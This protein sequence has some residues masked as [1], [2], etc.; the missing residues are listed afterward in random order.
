VAQT[1]DI[2]LEDRARLPEQVP[3][4]LPLPAA[5]QPERK[6]GLLAGLQQAA[7][8]ALEHRRLFLLLPYAMIAGL[9]VA[10][11]LPADPQPLLLGTAWPCSRWRSAGARLPGPGRPEWRLHSGS[12]SAC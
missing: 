9:I 12:A 10:F 6:G 2:A 11:E 7:A 1:G 8:K 5:W 3:P 4:K